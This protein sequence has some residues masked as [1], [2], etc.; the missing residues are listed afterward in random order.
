MSLTPEMK[1]EIAGEEQGK[2]FKMATVELDEQELRMVLDGLYRI[3]QKHSG[4]YAARA[5]ALYQR[6][7]RVQDGKEGP[8][9]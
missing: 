3:R 8:N 6:L 2:L 7:A 5:G 1:E 9:W 4:G